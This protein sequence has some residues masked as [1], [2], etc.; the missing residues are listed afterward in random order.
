[1]AIKPITTFEGDS[2]KKQE[3]ESDRAHHYFKDFKKRHLKREKYKQF[4]IKEA[5][6][7]QSEGQVK[8]WTSDKTFNKKNQK[9]IQ[10]YVDSEGKKGQCPKPVG[11]INDWFDYHKWTPRRRDYWQF[12]EEEADNQIRAMVTEE[13]PKIAK[14]IIDCIHNTADNR[15]QQ[16]ESGRLSLS[17]DESG[18]K[19]I[20]TDIDSLN[21]L[22]NDDVQRLEA[23]VSADVNAD[24]DVR[25]HSAAEDIILNPAYAELTRKLLE[26]VTNEEGTDS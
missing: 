9:H 17:Q 1:M 6:E 21:K 4:L 19:S 25:H 5:D 13:K 24:V 20:N 11:A 3:P 26:D 22:A 2:W 12:Q 14:E 7:R 18:A 23:T 16:H 15:K 8:F 10:L